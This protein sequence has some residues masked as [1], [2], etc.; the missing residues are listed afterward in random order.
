MLISIGCCLIVDWIQLI[1]DSDM[2]CVYRL[3][4]QAFHY[5][6]YQP[7]SNRCLWLTLAQ[8][9]RQTSIIFNVDTMFDWIEQLTDRMASIEIVSTTKNVT[10]RSK[11]VF[12]VV[13]QMIIYI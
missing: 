1:G 5:A 11:F 6:N 3:A 12:S 4:Q 13:S 7:L 8:I 10:N 9:N 2:K